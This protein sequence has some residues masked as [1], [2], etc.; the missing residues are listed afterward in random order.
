MLTYTGSRN[1]FTT[2]LTNNA[3]ATNLTFADTFNN[4]FGLELLHKFP[5]I[6]SEQSY[7]Y[8]G[9]QT[10]PNTQFVTLPVPM[11]KISTVVIT[12][13]NSTTYPGVGFNWFVRECPNL[14]YWNQLNLTRNI[15]SD[16]PQYF[17]VINGRLGLY[18][19]P[20]VGYNPITIIGQAE[21][22]ALNT[23]DITN[24]TVTIPKALTLL[25]TPAIGDLTATLSTNFL[26]P[27]GTYQILFSSGEQR[28]C[29]LTL[30]STA[31]VWT[32]ALTAVATTAV[33]IRTSTGGEIITLNSGAIAAMVG[34]VFQTT[35]Q[36]WYHIDGYINST[37]LSL[38]QPYT[39]TAVSTAACV[40]G[41]SSLIPQAYQMI[42][43]YRSA[44]LYYTV[45]SKDEGRMNKYKEMADTA[46]AVIRND[47]GN[48]TNDPT[49]EDNF[50]KGLINPNLTVNLTDST[51]SNS[52]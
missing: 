37:T 32:T 9:F 1:L 51:N 49:I 26:L 13:G 34:Y 8:N 27:T 39:G 12:V 4:Q 40:I 5:L 18:P 19:T 33:T 24:L 2:T 48:K 11:R 22:V 6:I 41:Q 17:M 10:L 45:V 20:A 3:S 38:S 28:L 23:A 7:T 47:Y 43:L 50:D 42:P 46:E 21:P 35:D 30:N 15:K 52:Y 16:I 31:V 29:T 44:E 25:A 36:Q 14:Q